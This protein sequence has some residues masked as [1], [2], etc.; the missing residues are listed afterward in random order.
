M[1]V[2]TILLV[3]TWSLPATA[4]A[5]GPGHPMPWGGWLGMVFAVVLVAALVLVLLALAKRLSGDATP[6]R[7]EPLDILKERLARGE[8]DIDEYEAR[9]RALE[10]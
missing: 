9:R 5:M 10:R 4:Q 3:G 6:A 8:I 2:I 1:R 7:R